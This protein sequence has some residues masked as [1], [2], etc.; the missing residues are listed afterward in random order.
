MAPEPREVISGGLL[1]LLADTFVLL[2]KARHL[3]WRVNGDAGHGVRAIIKQD[4]RDL[5]DAAD[6]I[7]R[8]VLALGRD[9]APSYSDLIRSS[10]ID[11]E[12]VVRS[13]MDMIRQIAD[14]HA[15]ILADIDTLEA[16]LP[17]HQDTESQ[18]L[19]D[20]LRDCHENCRI[21]LSALL[22]AKGERKH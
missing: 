3:S 15:Q 4:H 14:D 13:E 11:Q 6:K 8:H 19:L 1:R 20:H 16:A 18:H 7:A 12:L 2:Y 22:P 5:D 10:S 17:L 21:S 9:L